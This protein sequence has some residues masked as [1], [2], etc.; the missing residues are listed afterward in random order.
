MMDQAFSMV[1]LQSEDSGILWE[2]AFSHC[3]TPW[4]PEISSPAPELCDSLVPTSPGPETAGRII[5]IMDEDHMI[6]RKKKERKKASKKLPRLAD[7]VPGEADRP[8]MVEVSVPNVPAEKEKDDER[9]DTK[10]TRK[11]R[12][13]CLVSEG[14]EILNIVVPPKVSTVDE[15]ESKVL[16]DNLSYLEDTPVIK[17]TEILEEPEAPEK[18]EHLEHLQTTVQ[19]ASEPLA[20]PSL[21]KPAQKQG[22]SEDYFEKFTLLDHQ[23]S[24]GVPTVDAIQETITEQEELYEDQDDAVTKKT[25]PEV[26]EDAASISG[27]EITSEH[28]DEVFYGT[29]QEP[30]FQNTAKGANKE[31]EQPKSPLKKTGCDL[32]GSQE[33]ILTP[34]F[35]PEG[36]QKIIDLVLLE[37]P[38]AMAFMYSDLYADALGSRMIQDDTESMTSEKSFHS[39]ESD[40]EDRG[41]LEKFVL[42]DE[43]PVIQVDPLHNDRKEDEVKMFYQDAFFLTQNDKDETETPDDADE[44]TDF[45]RNSASSSP[46]EPIQL[47]QTEPEETRAEAKTRQV[48]FQDEREERT[49]EEDIGIAEAFL[50]LDTDVDPHALEASWQTADYKSVITEYAAKTSA[51]TSSKSEKQKLSFKAKPQKY[52]FIASH[53]PQTVKPITPCYKAFLELTPLL[54]VEM[55]EEDGQKETK[56]KEG[57]GSNSVCLSTFKGE[58]ASVE[59]QVYE[60][61]S[62]YE[63]NE[64]AFMPQQR[65]STETENPDSASF[66]AVKNT[67]QQELM[68][69][70]VE[71]DNKTVDV[72]VS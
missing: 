41:Y 12:L 43:T 45:F 24:S 66:T 28:V 35:L 37:E 70:A 54:P 32:F 36:P 51:A 31:E 67:S 44:I 5:F 72:P 42:K 19:V 61:I 9:K 39:Q 21:I 22:T 34:I 7:K 63:A 47:R 2:T 68:C 30:D 60:R 8:A 59:R 18:T 25:A 65:S 52:A 29:G 64:S 6:R 55:P 20:L 48:V 10:E 23:A 14:S 38:K 40:I 57:E 1:T 16:I 17:G 62:Q 53:V 27:L 15:E 56:P 4:A 46:C 26:S 69:D 13:F 58:E 49:T 11:Q 50:P 71:A 33:S 3:S